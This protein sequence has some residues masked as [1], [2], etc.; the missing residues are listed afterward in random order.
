MENAGTYI[1][2]QYGKEECGTGGGGVYITPT[3][4]IEGGGQAASSVITPTMAIERSAGQFVTPTEGYEQ[5]CAMMQENNHFDYT[6]KKDSLM[7]TS[8]KNL[9]R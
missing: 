9:P 3:Y 8:V 2:P 4:N 6:A 5:D 1:T 7:V